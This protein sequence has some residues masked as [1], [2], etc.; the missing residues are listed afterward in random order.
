MWKTNVLISKMYIKQF[1][2]F[3]KFGI[4]GFT[5]VLI[6]LSVFYLTVHLGFHY[7]IAN[8]T[9]F[10]ISSLNGFVLNKIWVFKSESNKYFNQIIKYYFVYISSLLL[11]ML[12]SFVYIEL[13][14]GYVFLSP[15]INLFITVPYNYMLSKLWIYK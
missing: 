2:Q 5:N 11:S 13:F 6:A 3:I 4:V 9:S 7:Q 14:G 12:M 15:I 1:T 8:V 10:I